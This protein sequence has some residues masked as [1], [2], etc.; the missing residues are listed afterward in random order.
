MWKY[1][2]SPCDAGEPPVVSSLAA[3]WCRELNFVKKEKAF[4][5]FLEKYWREEEDDGLSAVEWFKRFARIDESPRQIQSYKERRWK[6]GI[7]LYVKDVCEIANRILGTDIAEELFS[8]TLFRLVHNTLM[9][10][11]QTMLLK[12]ERA[13]NQSFE[14]SFGK[15]SFMT[16]AFETYGP[17]CLG[18]RGAKRFQKLVVFRRKCVLT[19]DS[20]W[21]FHF[22]NYTGAEY[23]ERHLDVLFSSTE[24]LRRLME[25]NNRDEG[26]SKIVFYNTLADSPPRE[27]REIDNFVPTDSIFDVEN[28]RAASVELCDAF[29][30]K[31]ALAKQVKYTSLKKIYP[32]AES[33][34]NQN[35]EEALQATTIDDDRLVAYFARNGRLAPMTMLQELSLDYPMEAAT[36]I[37]VLGKI[38]LDGYIPDV[39]NN[40]K[41]CGIFPLRDQNIIHVQNKYFIYFNVKTNKTILCDSMK[42]YT[43]LNK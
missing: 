15:K 27:I 25:L 39:K 20:V 31:L 38:Y 8:H 43:I 6:R 9:I 37:N 41:A 21:S 30:L 18:S 14:A 4:V 26:S 12:I 23:D 34:R 7:V 13:C 2:I 28:L 19:F 35:S 11:N 5:S 32:R 36:F 1:A 16:L 10:H 40:L 17:P 29:M 3:R 42:I 33:I 22:A 24:P